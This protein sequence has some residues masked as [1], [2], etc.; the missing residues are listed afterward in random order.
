MKKLGI[1]EKVNL[2]DVWKR[3][4]TEDI[5]NPQCRSSR[6]VDLVGNIYL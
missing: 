4:D 2:R 1:L 6:V 3:E 5:L